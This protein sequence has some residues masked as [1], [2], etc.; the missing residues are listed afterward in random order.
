MKAI[1]LAAGK[2]T[3]LQP[4]TNSTPQP[5]LK[6]NGKPILDIQIAS[7]KRIGI[8]EITIITGHLSEK[9]ENHC[10]KKGINTF[11][12]PF[13]EVSGT[14]MTLWIAKQELK[15]GFLFLYSDVLFDSDIM[16]GILNSK[17][18]IVLAIKKDGLRD[19]AEK[20]NEVNNII[21]NL[22]KN[23]MDKVNAE[24]IG[25]AKFSKSGAAK[26]LIEIDKAAKTN[27][28]A[29][30]IALINKLIEKNEL[31]TAY[32]IKEAQF[33]DVDFPDDLDKANE[34]F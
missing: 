1:I 20:V 18:D 2:A 31:V 3:R 24:F 34:I 17:K 8:K 11:F 27:L 14:A 9:V 33:I 15:N 29:S 30:F 6:I 21:K 22:S 12:N 25:L 16:G 5:L 4:L 13:Y 7:L 28:N 19:E 23:E 26:L 32:D 10:Q